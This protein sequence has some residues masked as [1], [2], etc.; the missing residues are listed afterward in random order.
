M[1]A[2]TGNFRGRGATLPLVT[3]P[4]GAKKG[5]EGRCGAYRRVDVKNYATIGKPLCL[6]QPRITVCV[7]GTICTGDIE[8]GKAQKQG[9]SAR[10]WACELSV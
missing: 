1:H 2:H 6:W 4:P 5:M 3:R 9:K 10:N 7:P 8:V